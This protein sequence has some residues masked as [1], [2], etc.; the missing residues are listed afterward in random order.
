MVLKYKLLLNIFSPFSF[1]VLGHA[2][3]SVVFFPCLCCPGQD[4]RG[5]SISPFCLF[6]SHLIFFHD[7][8][9]HILW[10]PS[11]EASWSFLSLDISFSHVLLFF[12]C[13]YH[14]FWR[15]FYVFAF[16][17]SSS[18][19]VA[20]PGSAAGVRGALQRYLAGGYIG[21]LIFLICFVGFR[22]IYLHLCVD[23]CISREVG[24][25]REDPSY[26][27]GVLDKIKKEK[28]RKWVRH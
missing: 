9:D 4:L 3:Q 27:G 22:F 19:E 23:L 21:Y 18:G 12:P 8:V 1:H 14:H 7:T 17:G 15:W 6:I 26:C 5:R 16:W 28:Q 20:L 24:L 10:P 13:L 25:H 11:W 2:T